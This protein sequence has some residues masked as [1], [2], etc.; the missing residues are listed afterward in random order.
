MSTF[1]DINTQVANDLG[2]VTRMGT[3]L[4]SLGSTITQPLPASKTLADKFEF[5]QERLHVIAPR[6]ALP[7]IN[8]NGSYISDRGTIAKMRLLT[9]LKDSS[10]NRSKAFADMDLSPDFASLTSGTFT[11]FF[12]TDVSVSHQEKVQVNSVFGDNEVVYYFGRNPPSVQLSGILFDSIAIDWFTKFLGLYEVA[13]RGSQLGRY[14][15]LIEFVLPNMKILGSIASFSHQQSSANDSPISF[16][17][18]IIPKHIVPTPIKPKTGNMTNLGNI[19][20]FSVGRAGFGGKGYSLQVGTAM[21]GVTNTFG[22]G[23][24]LDTFTAELNTFRSSVISPV[25]GMISVITKVVKA[26]TGDITS[27][28]SAFSTPVNRILGDI[29]NIASQVVSIA[30]LIEQGTDNI[31]RIPKNIETNLKNTIRALKSSSGAVSRMPE[32]ISQI[33]KR[34]A[35]G[36]SIKRGSAILSSKG[37]RGR[38]K[39][40]LLNSGA[41][42]S[43]QKAYRI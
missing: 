28:I 33:I 6:N 38:S 41:P 15:E 34:N 10:K 17:L 36:G 27:L 4:T 11:K 31:T 2:F 43:T 14:F 21:K 19:L 12:L 40:Y 42:Y 24:I 29:T 5:T 23:G 25:Y 16:S 22:V 30:N 37:P 39:A 35:L 20:D 3:T 13:T 1:S 26:T 18:Q 7:V 8:S 9:P 32:N